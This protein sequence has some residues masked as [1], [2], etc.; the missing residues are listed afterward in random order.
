V[1]T[2]AGY[3]PGTTGSQGG[4]NNLATP[5]T[6]YQY[7]DVG[8]KVAI[9]PRVHHNREVTLKLTVE[10]S[11]VG[12]RIGPNQDQ[13]TFGTRNIESTIRLMDGETNFLAGLIQQ[14]KTNSSTKTPF[15]GDLP[16][17]GRAFTKT[18]K[19]DRRT[20]LVLTMTPH[21][22]RIPDI[23]AE[24]RA[25]MWVG[26]GNNLTFRGVS[27]RIESQSGTGDPFASST[28]TQST[29][30]RNLQL[31]SDGEPGNYI[32]P[33]GQTGTPA[34]PPPPPPGTPPTDPFRRPPASQ[35]QPS[36]NLDKDQARLGKTPAMQ[37][38][39]A[40]IDAE[41]SI[42][43][44]AP[45]APRIG[46]QPSSLTL[47]P[48]ESKIWNVIGMDL[49]GLVASELVF[50][51]DPRAMTAT[52]VV[53]GSAIAIDPA[54][55]PAV[56]V[57]ASSGTIRV[58]NTNGKPLAF[59]GGGQVLGVRVHGGL[60]GETFLV[61]DNPDFRDSDGG[62]VVAAVAGGRARVQ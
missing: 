20:D 12:E 24:D 38:A 4:V 8:I 32:V 13:P 31:S 6:S 15:L 3:N 44:A 62:S 49:E 47:G 27:P 56:T 42:A 25:P 60:T 45:L 5:Y 50:R 51:F 46:P 2:I 9:E 29:N 7:Q 41:P 30:P 17:I 21:I 14:N 22:I 11:N 59:L 58:K 40:S 52:D 33:E 1:T 43:A 26:T 57:D 19:E 16:F 35:Q 10:V 37:V 48:G 55:P 36:T 34:T 61:M 28:S 54:A 18:S 53:L 23:T 39:A